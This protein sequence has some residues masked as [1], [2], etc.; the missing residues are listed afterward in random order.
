M[1]I[2]I[3]VITGKVTEHEDAPVVVEV[4]VEPV[5]EVTVEPTV[6]PTPTEGV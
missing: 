1:R 6:E 2:E 4:V 3:N 5:A